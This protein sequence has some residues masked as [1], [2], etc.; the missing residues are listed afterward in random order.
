[1]LVRVLDEF[2]GTLGIVTMEDI[3]EELVGEI[4]DEHDEVEEDVQEIGEDLYL[5]DCSV[6]LEDFAAQFD[7]DLESENTTVGGYVMEK[8]GGVP[9]VGEVY[10]DEDLTITVRE[11]DIQRIVKVEVAIHHHEEEEADETEEDTQN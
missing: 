4:W 10:E 5:V 7:L 8:F 11:K 9:E 1:M 2:G 6:N 3:L